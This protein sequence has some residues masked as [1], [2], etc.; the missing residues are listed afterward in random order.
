MARERK[1][2]E[3]C[4][5]GLC[6]TKSSSSSVVSTLGVKKRRDGDANAAAVAVVWPAPLC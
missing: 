3:L 2:G 4:R 5:A 6:Q 1:K